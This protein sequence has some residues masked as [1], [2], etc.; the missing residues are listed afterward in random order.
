M[1][2]CE[3][4]YGPKAADAIEELIVLATNEP[5][6]PCKQG[7]PCPLTDRDGCNPLAEVR[8]RMPIP[9]QLTQSR[10]LALAVEAAQRG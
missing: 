6:C 1:R 10:E 9:V 2:V 7:K 8:T 5:T 3:A 4:I